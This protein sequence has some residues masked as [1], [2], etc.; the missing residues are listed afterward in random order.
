VTAVAT[1]LEKR[2]DDTTAE[3]ARELRLDVLGMTCGS[4]AA[5]VERTLNKQPGVSASVNFATG[6]ALVHLGGTAPTLDALRDAVRDRGYD[7]RVHVDEADERGKREERTWLVRVAIAWPLAALAMVV[8]MTWMDETWARWAAF[9]LATPVQAVVGWPFLRNATRLARHGAANMDTLVALGTLAAYAYSV[10]A[11]LAPT[12]ADGDMRSLY[13]ESAAVILAFVALGRWL[14]ARA[15]GRASQALRHLLELGAKDA[16]V[17]RGGKEMRVPVD[18][19]QRGWLLKVLPGERF[20]VDGRVVDGTSHVDA[21]MLT[22]ESMP[23]A[24]GPG[25]DVAAATVNLDGV[26][27]FEATRVGDETTLAQIAQLVARAQASRAPIQRLAD[28]IAG[29]F[30]PV[31]LAISAITAV[32]WFAIDGTVEGALGPAVAVLIIA[33]PCALGLATPAALMVGTGRAAQLGIVIRSADILERSRAIDTVVFDKTGTLTEGRMRLVEVAGCVEALERAAA[34]EASSEHPIARAIVDGAASRGLVVPAA[35]AF[36]SVAGRGTRAVVDGTEV[37][38]GRRSFLEEEN[39]RV[40]A[41]IERYAS[42]LEDRGWSTAWVGWDGAARGVVAVAD[43]L[44]PQA[45]RAVAGVERLGLTT[46]LMTGDTRRSA[47][48]I[49][50]EVPVG[51]VVAEVHPEDK[52]A[53]IERLQA[54]GHVVAM[55]GDGI[56]DGPALAAADVGIALGSGSDVAIE[57]SDLTLVSNDPEGVVR[58]IALSRRTFRTIAQNLGW[59]FG[60]NVAAI[61]LAALGL[62][63]PV[64]AAAAM[65]LSSVSVLANSLRLRRFGLRDSG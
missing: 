64:V 19:V 38:V 17:L 4:C 22:G 58:A 18:A 36:T 28:R 51:R 41:S 42:D 24:T 60:Y 35:T 23:V 61:P 39:L 2:V 25:D 1:D 44:R 52:I 33:C 7:L 34:V 16:R 15:K 37:L 32:A 20:P 31:V 6:E 11:L 50:A 62:L 21:S 47:D 30:V 40:P 48:A 8:S 9:A 13:F 65:A 63:N 5:R 12:S 26:V 53:E 29:L 27:T 55:V 56:N 45:A 57:A 54:D 14:E 10:W 49:A 43:T 59:A 46:V 3:A